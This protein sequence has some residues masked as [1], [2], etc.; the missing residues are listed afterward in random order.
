[1]VLSALMVRLLADAS[2]PP[3]ISTT[4]SASPLMSVTASAYGPTRPPLFI[5]AVAPIAVSD[6]ALISRSPA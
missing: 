5:S 6:R 2:A 4:A 3:P 1:M